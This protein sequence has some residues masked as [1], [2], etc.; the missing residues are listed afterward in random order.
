MIE[1]NTVDCMIDEPIH[2]KIKYLSPSQKITLRCETI[3]NKY[4][5]DSHAHYIADYD[6]EVDIALSPSFGG[7]YRGVD[8]MGIFWGMLPALGQ[9]VGVKY[10][11]KDVM[12][13]CKFK[14]QVFNH[15]LCEENFSKIH[16]NV[17]PFKEKSPICEIFIRRRFC[18]EG[19]SREEIKHGNVR[20]VLYKPPVDGPF[21][22]VIDIYGGG[23]GLVE[24]KAALFASHGFAALLLPYFNYKD[25]PKDLDAVEAEYFLAAIEYFSSLPFVLPGISLVGLSYGGTVVMFLASI[26]KQLT[27]VVSISPSYIFTVPMRYEGRYFPD[28][29]DYPEGVSF[30]NL[31][32]D[33]HGGNILNFICSTL[34]EEI[35]IKIEN[36]S[37]QLLVLV[38]EDDIGYDRRIDGRRFHERM[39]QFGK[40]HQINVISYPNAGHFIEPSYL[41]QTLVHYNT[42][43]KIPLACGGKKVENAMACIH[44]WKEI[45]KF[46]NN[47]TGKGYAIN[48]KL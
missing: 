17:D 3:E 9:M 7:S 21:K 47:N 30:D 39:K 32:V 40:E 14:L 42:S 20:A 33:E 46:L 6:G 28:A 37:A 45:L 2:I 15:F 34:N 18:R 48:S 16:V 44:S 1:V 13:G 24:I 36:S 23:G 41:P 8:S 4:V 29:M 25:I 26:C 19:V 11:P 22:G 12:N 31:G 35:Q 10:Q 27:G 5:Y 43:F 38:G